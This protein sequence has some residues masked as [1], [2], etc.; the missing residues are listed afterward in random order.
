[1]DVYNQQNN[2]KTIKKR[3]VSQSNEQE[4]NV[5][6]QNIQNE[7][8][9]GCFGK[10]RTKKKETINTR[11]SSSKKK[12][13]NNE[14]I[15]QKLKPTLPLKSVPTEKVSNAPMTCLQR[16][17]LYNEYPFCQKS[18]ESS[19]DPCIDC[20]VQY[21]PDTWENIPKNFQ[22]LSKSMFDNNEV[23]V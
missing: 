20:N 6:R 5:K 16:S 21:G 3:K 18:L 15:N 13:I 14:N 9:P 17:P 1:M 11:K 8:S 19:Y 22:N 4:R 23:K 7:K 12:L 2:Y 10:W